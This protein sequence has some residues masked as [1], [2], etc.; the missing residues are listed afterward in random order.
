VVSAGTRGGRANPPLAQSESH[1]V[2]RASAWV[3]G[4]EPR[5]MSLPELESAAGIRWVDIHHAELRSARSLGTLNRICHGALTHRMARD[6]ATPRRFPAAGTYEPTTI[7]MTAG[8]LVRHLQLDVNRG[9][10]VGPVASVLKPVQLLVGAGWLLSAWLPT[11]LFRG[12]SAALEAD[13]DGDDADRLHT[14]VAGER[15]RNR[16]RSGRAHPARAGGRLRSPLVRA[17][18]RPPLCP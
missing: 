9:D 6:L 8:F 18:T 12:S 13:C 11:R 7:R 3:A 17:L 2:R 1:L 10:P 4:E 15:L 16:R 5:A 14:A